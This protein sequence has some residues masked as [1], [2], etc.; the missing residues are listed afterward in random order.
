M[1][2]RKKLIEVSLPLATTDEGSKPEKE[3]PF[4]NGMSTSDSIPVSASKGSNP[5]EIDD[6]SS[7]SSRND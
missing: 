3:V 2:C 7:G 6:R 1:T 4:L 5:T